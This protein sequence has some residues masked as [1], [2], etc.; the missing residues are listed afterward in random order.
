[1][2]LESAN[3]DDL[4]SL[5][6]VRRH[7]SQPIITPWADDGETFER[8]HRNVIARDF[9]FSIHI[10]F[11]LPEVDYNNEANGAN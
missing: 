7:S 3:V 9:L 2:T 4:E 10:T 5:I 6:K 8:W 11:E 1:M